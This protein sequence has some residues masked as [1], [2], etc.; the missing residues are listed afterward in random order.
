MTFITQVSDSHDASSARRLWKLPAVFAVLV[1]IGNVNGAP[2]SPPLL[3]D[4]QSVG[5]STGAGY[6]SYEAINQDL[7]SLG[8]RNYAGP[9]PATVEITT[10]NLPDVPS[11][12]RVVDRGPLVSPEIDDWIGVDARLGPPGST[13]AGNPRPVMNIIVSNLNDGIY[14]WSSLHHDTLNQTGVV[15]YSF[16]DSNGSS[17]G[18]IDI[19]SAGEPMTTFDTMFQST[20]GAPVTLSL[21]VTE[22]DGSGLFAVRTSFALIN[23]LQITRVPEPH[24]LALFGFGAAILGVRFRVRHGDAE[25]ARIGFGTSSVSQIN[26]E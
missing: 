16:T 22:P 9:L 7:N 4:F 8:P 23:S 19:S 6:Q 20:G 5:G 26:K 18:T 10:S 2:V 12:F 15:A 24:S 14:T 21:T 17:N 11:D 25:R 13:V 1:T 3:I